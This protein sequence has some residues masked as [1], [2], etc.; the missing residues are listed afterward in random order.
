MVYEQRLNQI[1]LNTFITKYEIE[2][3]TIYLHSH[4]QRHIFHFHQMFAME[5]ICMYK[6][7]THQ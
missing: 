2:T 3:V 1:Q 4:C 7:N 6:H 5:P